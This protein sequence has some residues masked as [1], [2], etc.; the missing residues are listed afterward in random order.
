MRG[1]LV[2]AW[3]MGMLLV[4]M[5]AGTVCV[6]TAGR[7]QSSRAGCKRLDLSPGKDA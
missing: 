6:R 3:W 7:A 2:M 4:S 5:V 1:V